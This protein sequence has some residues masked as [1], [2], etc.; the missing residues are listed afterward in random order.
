[1]VG[2]RD[3]AAKPF[4]YATEEDQALLRISSPFQMTVLSYTVGRG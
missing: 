1:M 3:W 4:H 2:D